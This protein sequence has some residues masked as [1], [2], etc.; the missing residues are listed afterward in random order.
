MNVM[1]INKIVG[2][3]LLAALSMMVISTIGNILVNPD[4][5]GDGHGANAS[6]AHGAAG[7]TATATKTEEKK[8]EPEKPIGAVLASANAERGAKLTK[9]RCASC[10]TL[11]DGG[12][13]KVGPNLYGIVGRA[14]AAVDGYAYSKALKEKGG[15]WGFKELYAFLRNPRAYASGSKMVL[16]TRKS[17]DRGDIILHLRSLAATPAALP[18][19][20]A[21]PQ[22]AKAPAPEKQ[23]QDTP[24]GDK[25]AGDKPAAD[26]PAADKPGG[27]QQGDA[28]PAEQP[29]EQGDAK[30][31]EKA[32]TET[33][34]VPDAKE[35][36]PAKPAGDSVLSLI[37]AGDADKGAKLAKRRCAACHTFN[38]GG[39]NRVGPNLFGVL[40]RARGGLEG[41]NYSRGMKS[42]GGEWGFADMYA[43]LEDP[44]KFIKGTKMVL[45]TRK[46]KDRADII[47]YLRTIH[48]NP[49]ALPAK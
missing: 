24:A 47:A 17:A 7:P 32:P 22:P 42:K 30:P 14:K 49:P 21:A 33:A 37:A 1:E 8:P 3:I 26:K 11:N 6:A 12:A 19:P 13:N 15:Q 10:H 18:K 23:G 2:A 9:S 34:K 38:K 20:E 35:A 31:A 36:T 39:A 5:H 44:K 48:D 40:G 45:K 16:R 4:A 27:D 46:S 25:P 41:Y 29:K 43:Y 28:K